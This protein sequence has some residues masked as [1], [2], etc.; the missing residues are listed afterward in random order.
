MNCRRIVFFLSN[1]FNDFLLRCK[2]MSMSFFKHYCWI[3]IPAFS[4]HSSRPYNVEFLL[5]LFRIYTD[6]GFK[7]E[8]S[9][10]TLKRTMYWL[11]EKLHQAMPTLEAKRLEKPSPLNW[12][13]E[14]LGGWCWLNIQTFGVLW[15]QRY[16]HNFSYIILLHVLLLKFK[17]M[18]HF[19]LV[20]YFKPF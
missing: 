5:I 13:S 12:L 6:H 14:Q 11:A 18:H 15:L 17:F 20:W 10:Q 16:S 7:V 8:F 4:V 1:G 3:M 9:F 2:N 19:Y